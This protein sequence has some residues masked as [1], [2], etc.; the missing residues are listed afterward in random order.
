[1]STTRYLVHCLTLDQLKKEYRRLAK[2]HHP[3]AGGDLAT[4]QDLN[5]EYGC[6]KK[7]LAGVS[8]G[9][10]YACPR[11][12][13]SGRRWGYSE[14]VDWGGVDEAFRR[15][16][17]WVRET[18]KK[19][20]EQYERDMALVYKIVLRW[21]AWGKM[22]GVRCW[23]DTVDNTVYCSG[24]TFPYKED[25]KLCG[26]WWDKENRRWYFKGLPSSRMILLE[27]WWRDN[28]HR[29]REE[30]EETIKQQ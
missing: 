13:N 8:E 11:N 23:K 9:R 15:A 7:L 17:Q 19:Q 27:R 20:H 22:P 1:M 5:Q 6:R 28:E 30:Y 24:D 10:T 18:E 4:M 3:D 25:L 26:M 2:V 16:E 21:I 12:T 29:S 14:A